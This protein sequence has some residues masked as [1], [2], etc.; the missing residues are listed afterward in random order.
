[1]L[2]VPF[3]SVGLQL[4]D[5]TVGVLRSEIN[6]EKLILLVKNQQAVCDASDCERRNRAGM[7]D[8]RIA[9]CSF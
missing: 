4:S 5:A 8:G 3:L 6:V 2:H 1:M 7:T 9:Q